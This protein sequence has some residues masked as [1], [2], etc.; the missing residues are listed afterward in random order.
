[1]KPT[2]GPWI[3]ISALAASFFLA[4]P[5]FAQ[6]NNGAS[7]DTNYNANSSSASADGSTTAENSTTTTNRSGSTTE[8][9][10]ESTKNAASKVKEGTKKFYHHAKRDVKDAALEARIK[11]ALLEDNRTRHEEIHVAADRGEVM[12]TGAV[13]SSTT[14]EHAQEVVARLDGVRDVKNDLVYPTK[15]AEQE[16]SKS[17]AI[18]SSAGTT[19]PPYSTTAPAEQAPGH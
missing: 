2:K 9:V 7:S 13:D 17:G 1:M 15:H 6:A 16:S 12:L 8:S 5:I 18:S 19:K 11:K 10:K 4:S 14:A 3:G